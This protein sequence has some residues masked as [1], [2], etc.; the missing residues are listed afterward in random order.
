MCEYEDNNTSI[1][2]DIPRLYDLVDKVR[3]PRKICVKLLK[4][5]KGNIEVSKFL[6]YVMV[7]YDVDFPDFYDTT[8]HNITVD[9]LPKNIYFIKELLNKDISI[10]IIQKYLDY[11]INLLLDISTL[12]LIS[13]LDV[14]VDV[15]SK[16]KVL[17]RDYAQFRILEKS[18]TPVRERVKKIIN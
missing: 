11:I 16:I 2:D 17:R 13:V 4:Y 12:D 9:T 15:Y 6:Y 7:T 8:L 10:C 1:L 18:T 5:H 3:D 14:L